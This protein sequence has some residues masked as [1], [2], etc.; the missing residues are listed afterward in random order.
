MSSN[1]FGPI[2]RL[3]NKSIAFTALLG[4]GGIALVIAM[5]LMV[6]LAGMGYLPWTVPF[7]PLLVAVPSLVT[8][9]KVTMW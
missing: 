4:F 3:A 1:N 9:W 7:L 6:P 5:V 8:F 2:A